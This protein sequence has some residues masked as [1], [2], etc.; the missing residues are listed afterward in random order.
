MLSLDTIEAFAE[1]FADS[2]RLAEFE[3]HTGAGGTLRLRRPLASADMPVRP[4]KPAPAGA[5]VAVLAPDVPAPAPVGTVVTSLF[6]GV[7][8]AHPKKPSVENG[9]VEA[10]QILG[11]IEVMRLQNEIV[12]PVA[13]VVA[14]VFVQDGQPVEYGQPL[15]EIGAATGVSE[16]G[17]KE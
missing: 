4:A 1:A 6:V 8:R 10:G 15:F 16:T 17:E 11:T 9:A 5:P 3:M 2:P 13:G 7:F 12:A 14:F